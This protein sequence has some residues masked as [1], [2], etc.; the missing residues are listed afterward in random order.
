MHVSAGDEHLV[1]AKYMSYLLDDLGVTSL[2]DVGTGTGR[3]IKFLLPRHPNVRLA[4]IEP[5]QALIDE[6]VKGGVPPGV[7]TPGR[8][9]ALPYEDEAFDAVCEFGALHHVS[10]PNEVIGEMLRVARKAVFISDTNRF[11]RGSHHS[12][13]A[14][15]GL[16]SVGLWRLA[17]WVKTRGKGF[18]ISEG[19][20]VAYSYSVFDS[21]SLLTAWADRVILFPTLG[22]KSGGLFHP[23]LTSSHLLCCAIKEDRVL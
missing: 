7:I 3:A 18:A 15:V 14:K 23:L 8:G 12:R 9:E 11:G 10:K 13:L 4:G 2:L 17:D 16:A 1:A 20:G 5:V 22:D 19:D 21:M 6:A